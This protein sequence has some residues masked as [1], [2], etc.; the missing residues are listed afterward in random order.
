MAEK[1][2]IALVPKTAQIPAPKGPLLSAKQIAE[3]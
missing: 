1:R 2:A 3:E